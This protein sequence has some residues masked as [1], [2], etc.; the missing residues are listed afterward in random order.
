MLGTPELSPEAFI[1]LPL[2]QCGETKARSC[3]GWCFRRGHFHWSEGR[4]KKACVTAL[5]HVPCCAAV[6]AA[7]VSLERAGVPWEQGRSEE[8]NRLSLLSVSS[9][10]LEPS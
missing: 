5:P 2:L 7:A 8:Q 10:K 1:L 9:L 4:G 3:Y 6:G